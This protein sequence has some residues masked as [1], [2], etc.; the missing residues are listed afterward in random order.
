[1]RNIFVAMLIA[2]SVL[3]SQ[4]TG[5]QAHSPWGGFQGNTRTGR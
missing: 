5:A 2:F 1:M 3:A 4:A